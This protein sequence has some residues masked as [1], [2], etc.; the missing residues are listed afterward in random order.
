[1]QG[2]RFSLPLALALLWA[3]PAP[4]APE[5]ISKVN[6][7]IRVEKNAEAGNLSTVNGSVRVAEGARIG[8]VSTVNGSVEIGERVQLDSIDTV[9][10]AIV[11]AADAKAARNVS[12][13]NGSIRLE[14]GVEV[15]GSV[16]NVNGR[17]SLSGAHVNGNIRTVSGDVNIGA[18][19][20]VRGG[21]LVDRE[22]GWRLGFSRKPHIVIGPNA[23]VEGILEFRREVE[24]YVSDRAKISEVKGATANLFSGDQP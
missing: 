7:S 2:L 15:G 8:A 23:V 5:D 9:N 11:L 16:T 13:V 3:I 1:M 24:L 20:L 12:T 21:L 18:D 22:T 10:G 4:A 17:I 14:A 6:S 19:S